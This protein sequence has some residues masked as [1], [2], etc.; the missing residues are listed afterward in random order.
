[1]RRVSEDPEVSCSLELFP[2]P[3]TIVLGPRGHAGRPAAIFRIRIS[4]FGLDRPAGGAESRALAALE[5]QLNQLGLT[6]R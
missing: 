2:L 1:V 6:R 3:S 5:E 4:R